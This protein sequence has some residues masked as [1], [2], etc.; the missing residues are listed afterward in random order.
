M[1]RVVHPGSRSWFLPIPDPEVKK[2]PD[3]GSATLMPTKIFKTVA[4]YFFF[5]RYYLLAFLSIQRVIVTLFVG[6]L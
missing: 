3:P 6:K 1:I 5:Y 4:F 2:V